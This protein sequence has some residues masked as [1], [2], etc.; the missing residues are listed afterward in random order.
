M[1]LNTLI[2]AILS[3]LASGLCL[4]DLPLTIE[5]LLAKDNQFRLTLDIGYANADRDN[6]NAQYDLV[7]TG[8]NNFIQL[9]VAVGEQRQNSDTFTLALGGRYGLSTETELSTRLTAIS[10]DTRLSHGAQQHSQSADQLSQWALGVNHQFSEDNDS[11]ALLGFAEIVLAENMAIEGTEYVHGKTAQL[12][13]TTYRSIDPVVLSLTAGYRHSWSR[14]TNDQHINPGDLLFINPSIGFAINSEVT[15]TGGVQF[16]FRSRDRIDGNG[17]GIRTS[18]TSIDF[19]LGYA[20]SEN[21]TIN[22]TIRSD[23]SGNSGAQANL[24]LLHKFKD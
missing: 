22:L 19:G 17:S 2:V 11:P 12:G 24:S 18:Q 15:L 5:D 21:R 10:S 1:K 3:A 20:S 16:K 7:Q 13:L 23:I 8:D 6:V 14:E 4:A 9:P